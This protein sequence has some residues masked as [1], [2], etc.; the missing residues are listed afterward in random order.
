MP[1]SWH[2]RDRLDYTA[3]KG[4]LVAH[5][6]PSA[7]ECG[8]HVSQGWA[9]L[10][11]QSW[12]SGDSP[13]PPI[14]PEAVTG[15]RHVFFHS[16]IAVGPER[17]AGSW[18]GGG[19]GSHVDLGLDPKVTSSYAWGFRGRIHPACF[20]VGGV[21]PTTASLPSCG[22]VA[23]CVPPDAVGVGSSTFWQVGAC[24]VQRHP[25]GSL[26]LAAA[27]TFPPCVPGSHGGSASLPNRSSIN[28]AIISKL[29]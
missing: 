2:T 21:G 8:S 11:G 10:C 16:C 22:S 24:C 26:N 27:R 5:G 20:L 3:R 7:K 29:R 23:R 1:S 9:K 4:T 18:G 14:V 15:G 17:K 28:A 12:V 19:L 6:L 25:A 13:A